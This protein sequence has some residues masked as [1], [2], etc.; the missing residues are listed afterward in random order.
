M[1]QIHP[2]VSTTGRIVKVGE[3]SWLTDSQLEVPG[4]EEVGLVG[5]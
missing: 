1:R 5:S 3:D 2:P 4:G